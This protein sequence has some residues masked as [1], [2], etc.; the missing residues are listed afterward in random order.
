MLPTFWELNHEI[1]LERC[2][3]V[4]LHSVAGNG[5][6]LQAMYKGTGVRIVQT[7]GELQGIAW[8]CVLLI[9]SEKR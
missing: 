2:L 5:D 9:P 8:L 1:F 6:P 3:L 7:A 4:Y